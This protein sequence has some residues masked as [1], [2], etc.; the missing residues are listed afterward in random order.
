MFDEDIPSPLPSSSID[1]VAIQDKPNEVRIRPMRRARAK[2][3]G[4]Q[5]NSLLVEY[6]VCDNENFIHCRNRFVVGG[7]VAPV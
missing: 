5:V 7:Y 1:D 6:D 4:Q 2:L 3:L